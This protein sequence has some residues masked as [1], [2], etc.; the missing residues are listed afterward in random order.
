MCPI[1]GAKETLRAQCPFIPL[2]MMMTMTS[3]ARSDSKTQ[4]HK[5]NSGLHAPRVLRCGGRTSGGRHLPKCGE[6]SAGVDLQRILLFF[7]VQPLPATFQRLLSCP[8]LKPSGRGLPCF[9]NTL[10]SW[11]HGRII[12]MPWHPIASLCDHPQ[13][14]RIMHIAAFV[15]SRTD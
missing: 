1:G 15:F 13:S 9:W 12:M 4:N 10:A 7:D 14:R 6:T 5:R 11:A 2:T 8:R 3:P